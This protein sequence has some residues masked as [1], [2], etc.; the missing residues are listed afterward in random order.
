[1]GTHSVPEAPRRN[2]P[3]ANSLPRSRKRR[4][5]SAIPSR[6]LKEGKRMTVAE[7]VQQLQRHPPDLRVVVDGYEDGYDDLSPEQIA[8][9]KIALNTGKHRWEGMHGDLHGLTRH[10]PD[11]AEVVEAL[12]LQRTSN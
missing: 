3:P 9:M 4:P 12:V 10:A 7:L 2:K 5:Y 8:E 6:A 1:M 11:D